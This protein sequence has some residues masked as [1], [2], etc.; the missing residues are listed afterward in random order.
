M[1]FSQKEG[2]ENQLSS[3]TTSG[4]RGLPLK[5][6]AAMEE[7]TT[8]LLRE[9]TFAQEPRTLRVPFT[10]GSI[11]SAYSKPEWNKQSVLQNHKSH[12]PITGFSALII[13]YTDEIPIQGLPRENLRVSSI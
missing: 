5:I 1:D 8:T 12:K 2:S 4:P 11:S 10:A 3:T 13:K 6:I 7:V 9:G